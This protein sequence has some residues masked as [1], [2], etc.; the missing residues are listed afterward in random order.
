MKDFLE[1][2]T[3]VSTIGA[4]IVSIIVLFKVN[5][6]VQQKTSSTT[7]GNN[8]STQNIS[9]NKNKQAGRDIRK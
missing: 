8:N 7:S 4:F 2:A 6:L 5:T 1:I 9:G 3:Q